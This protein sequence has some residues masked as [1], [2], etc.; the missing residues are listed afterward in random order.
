MYGNYLSIQI[1]KCQAIYIK[2]FMTAI[3]NIYSHYI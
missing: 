1:F 2:V 3:I